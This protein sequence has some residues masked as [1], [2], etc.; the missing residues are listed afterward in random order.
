M[1]QWPISNSQ[2]LRFKLMNYTQ[3][4][5]DKIVARAK[6][7]GASDGLTYK[8]GHLKLDSYCKP[9]N[10]EVLA[11][12][13]INGWHGKYDL[14]YAVQSLIEHLER[15][16]PTTATD[17]SSDTRDAILA[18][19]SDV[20]HCG[21]YGTAFWKE[22]IGTVWLT[23]GDGDGCEPFTDFDDIKSKLMSVP[24]VK[25]VQF[26]PESDPMGE[27]WVMLGN[28]GTSEF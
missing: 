25:K 26:S 28:F 13:I 14:I 3:E 16:L 1:K 24:G 2:T 9:H 5:L 4:D 8:N 17:A 21:D 27:E 7:L 20:R 19:L 22:S 6:E 10:A 23:M 18:A 12:V 15:P 11:S